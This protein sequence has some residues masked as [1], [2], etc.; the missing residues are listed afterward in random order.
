MYKSIIFSILLIISSC[1]TKR[2]CLNPSGQEVDWYTIFFM[3]LSISPDDEIYYGYFEPGFT[4]LQFRKYDVNTFPP[5]HITRYALSS[6][7]DFNY[8]FWNDD[9]T[10]K[11]GSSSSASST[12]AHAKGSLVYDSISGAFLLHSLPRFP[13]RTSD[14][15]IL[16]ELPSNAGSYGQNF[17]CISINKSTAELI[18]KL[19][20]CINASINKSV[21]SDRVNSTPNPWIQSLIN[22]KMNSTCAIEHTVNILSLGGKEFTF[23]GKNYKNKI[24]PY[25]T[26]MR[27]AYNDHFYVRTWSRPS[28][29]PALYDTYNLVNVLEVKYDSFSYGVT[30]EH[31]KWVI[32]YNKNIVCFADINHTESQKER[33]GHIVC[34]ENEELHT[35]MKNAII[36]TDG[37]I[38]YKE[39]N[40]QY[41]EDISLSNEEINNIIDETLPVNDEI[42]ESI[43]EKE[44]L[45]NKETHSIENKETN[46]E[47]NHNMDE[48]K[49]TDKINE[50]KKSSDERTV[51]SIKETMKFINGT[52]STDNN[53]NKSIKDDISSVNKINKLVL[54]FICIMYC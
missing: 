41:T 27:Q 14:N 26:T 42:E 46:E 16:E 29:A 4:S 5:T 21:D 39:V 38:L 47:H 52:P 50:E 15:I 54:L 24:I 49:R 1:S 32:S 37:D 8:F 9:K 43:E 6:E 28:L 22:N 3:P 40:T 31:S 35:I 23:Y 20:N 11:D 2:V 25:D 51:S 12:K 44:K 18:A 34:F 45:N 36:S 10:V 7:S 33:G 53:D 19:L 17:L 13:T 48:E 30:K